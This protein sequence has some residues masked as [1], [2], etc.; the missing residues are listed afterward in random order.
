MQLKVEQP[1]APAVPCVTRRQAGS[2]RHRAPL[3]QQ[4]KVWESVSLRRL[5]YARDANSQHTN[6]V[7]PETGA[8]T[9]ISTHC[10]MWRDSETR[11]RHKSLEPRVNYVALKYAQRECCCRCRITKY[12]QRSPVVSGGL[13]SR[14]LPSIQPSCCCRLYP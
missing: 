7:N 14:G 10:V 3:Q 6:P 1:E 4:K 9:P 8:L 12:S 5:L 2:M 13:F 11:Y